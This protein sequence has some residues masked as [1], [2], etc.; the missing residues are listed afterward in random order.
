MKRINF[1]W[2]NLIE[3]ECNKSDF[4][5]DEKFFHC[6]KCQRTLNINKSKTYIFEKVYEPENKKVKPIYFPSK[7]SNI[8]KKTGEN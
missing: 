1:K 6:N 5:F 2:Q 3:C 8:V 7:K 4:I